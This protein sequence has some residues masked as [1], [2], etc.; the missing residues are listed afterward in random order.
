MN[1]RTTS[2]FA[3][4]FGLTALWAMTAWSDGRDGLVHWWKVKDLNGDGF[5]QANEVYDVMT[6]GAATPLVAEYVYQSTDLEAGAQPVTIDTD[7]EL[8]T[9]RRQIMDAAL[10]FHNPTNYGANGNVMMNYQA[11]RLPKAASIGGT[12]ATVFA[13][14][15]WDGVRVKDRD[16]SYNYN[17][18]LYANNFNDYYGRGWRVGLR[19]YDSG[20][21]SSFYPAIFCG[22]Q[23]VGFNHNSSPITTSQLVK[24][25][26]WF[27]IAYSFK[28]ETGEDGAKYVTPIVVMRMRN[29]G[30]SSCRYH[31]FV[32]KDPVKYV[33]NWDQYEVSVEPAYLGF[34]KGNNGVGGS[35]SFL[36]TGNGEDSFTGD[37]HEVKVY[38]RFMTVNEMLQCMEES[39]PLCSIGSRN[40]N[41]DEFTDTGAADVYEP[42]TMPFARM[43]KTLNAAHPSVS[44]KMDVIENGHDLSR[45]VELKLIRGTGFT[46]G[47]INVS[48]GGRCFGSL[49]VP[50]DGDMR[51]LVPASIMKSLPKDS[52]T[53]TYPLTLTISR[54]DNLAGDLQI[55]CLNVGAAWQLGIMDLS[56]DEFAGSGGANYHHNYYYLMGD[57]NLKHFS[58]VTC[59]DGA[60][61][62]QDLYFA[63]SDWAAANC[64]FNLSFRAEKSKQDAAMKIYL[65][66]TSNA[67]ETWT[68]GAR[69]D[70]HVV[71][72]PPGTLAGG[73]NL[74]RFANV[75]N[76]D[77]WVKLDYV[78]LEPVMPEGFRNKDAGMVMILK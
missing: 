3:F 19:C 48:A 71:T 14:I 9:M 70:E 37:I 2:G 18:T 26:Y 36:T 66:D 51:F 5:L 76:N 61:K 31:T 1:I 22:S 29:E 60:Y 78:R 55:D 40:G 41:A 57:G 27:D 69:T 72:F 52:G 54:A 28:M 53:G 59:N 25:G 23:E 10:H 56:S 63:V 16:G 15:K 21:R 39:D 4:A 58:G 74:V 44:V 17:I 75:V 6:V 8:P 7:I 43:R 67:Y 45:L 32:T 49:A 34:H 73:N 30:D 12:I 47:R 62:N 65:N 33:S 77:T 42:A 38:N 64:A 50:A 24:A 46:D 13:R 20:T 11:V 35:D 68:V